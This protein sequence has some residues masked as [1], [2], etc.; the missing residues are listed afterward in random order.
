[1]LFGKRHREEKFQT[2]EIIS[3]VSMS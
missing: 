2:I 1:M 3:I